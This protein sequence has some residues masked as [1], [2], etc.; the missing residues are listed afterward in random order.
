MLALAY[1]IYRYIIRTKMPQ[2]HQCFMCKHYSF[3]D[4]CPAFPQGIPFEIQTGEIDHSVP[5]EGDNGV[6]F[7]FDDVHFN[8]EHKRVFIG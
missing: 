2:G 5:I 4:T 1:F 8:E 7:E 3:L 6:Q